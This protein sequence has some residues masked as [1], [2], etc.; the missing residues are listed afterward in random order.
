MAI[1]WIRENMETEQIIAAKPTQVTVEAEVVLPGGLREEARV[2]YAD[3]T[4]A[5]NG[6]ELAGSRITADGRVNFRVLY[7][8]GD[9]S[10][11]QALETAAD[12][13]QALPLKEDCPQ[14]AAARLQPQAQVQRVTAKAFNGRLLLQAILAL[15]AE[16]SLPRTVSF[17]RD[18]SGEDGLVRSLQTLSLQR[19][20]GEGETQN[21][22]REEF[23]LSDVL[24]IKDTLFATAEAQVEDI[25]GGEDGRATVTGKITIDACHTSAMPGRP[26][27]YTRHTMPFEQ[28]VALSG[29]LGTALAARAEVKDVAALSQET[30]GEGRILRAEIQLATALTAVEDGAQ[31]ILRDVFTTQGDMLEAQTQRVSF[32]TGTVNE[33]AAESGRAMIALP[34]GS[35]RVKTPLLAFIRPV[36]TGAERQKEKLRAEGV[37]D[38]TLIYLTDEGEAPVSVRLEEPFRAAFITQAQPED[39]LTL[40]AA[41]VEPSAVTGDRV[42][43]KYILRLQASGVRKG[44][45]E[46]VADVAS[47]PAPERKRGM[48]LYYLQPGEALWD[49]AKRYRVSLEDLNRL[50]PALPDSPAPGTPVLAFIR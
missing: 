34:E 41:Q 11:V 21:L 49:L 25:L 38:V 18:G 28:Q 22:L 17:I 32:R 29:A 16:A 14:G 3:A 6:G 24:K 39:A 40:T 8:Q 10:N 48:V 36:L 50:N 23:E 43:L 30:E 33:T 7:A 5:V 26:L 19:T 9:L 27:V 44:E 42:E 35:P 45:A 47:A 4:A 37:L 15:T 46:V 13:S 1:E 2:Y 12:F 20:V 31:T